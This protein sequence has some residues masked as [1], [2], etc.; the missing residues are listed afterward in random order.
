M[1]YDLSFAVPKGREPP[2][3]SELERYFQRRE[4]YSVEANEARY[5]NERTGTSFTFAWGVRP[6]LF[7]GELDKRGLRATGISFQLR[8]ARPPYFAL[9]AAI[10]LEALVTELGLSVDDPENGGMGI[11]AFDSE[12]FVR[13]WNLGNQ[14][15]I[16]IL[17]SS[18]YDRREQV[19]ELNLS[20][21]SDL[22]RAWKWNYLLPALCQRS[23]W[24]VPRVRFF[25]HAKG[26]IR[27]FVSWPDAIPIALPNV[28][29]VLL[30]DTSSE[31]G[32]L[33]D[34][35]ELELARQRGRQSED[36]APHLV[37]EDA[38]A[39]GF[40]RE[41]LAK[42]EPLALPLAEVAPDEILDFAR[43]HHSMTRL[44]DS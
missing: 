38:A 24:M 44:R 5:G 32:V 6:L 7:D 22:E 39:L 8:Y 17:I 9:E 21:P 10:E 20:S 34:M 16:N 27:S 33:V 12:A 43:V 36:V 2:S 11:G 35:S 41:L 13:T 30:L 4:G 25:R 40:V 23:G 14:G 37:I 3:N 29:C 31:T 42:S 1:S 15:T 28:D 18:I 19:S 26:N